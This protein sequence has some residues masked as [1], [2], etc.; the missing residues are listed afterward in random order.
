MYTFNTMIRAS[1]AVNFYLLNDENNQVNGLV[2]FTDLTGFSVK[3]QKFYGYDGLVN[4][5]KCFEVS[6]SKHTK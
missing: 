3:H 2:Y 1:L 5:T 4:G 6:A